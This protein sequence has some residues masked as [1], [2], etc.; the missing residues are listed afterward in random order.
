MPQDKKRVPVAPFLK[1][2]SSTRQRDQVRWLMSCAF[3]FDTAK[4]R[5]KP[6]ALARHLQAK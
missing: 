6:K 2:M 4:G 3:K 5:E 1:Q